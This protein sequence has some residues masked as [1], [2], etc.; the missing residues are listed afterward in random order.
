MATVLVIDDSQS[1]VV[2]F[3]KILQG[4]GFDYMVA[5]DGQSGVAMAKSGQPDLVLMDV[6]MPGLNGFQA[7]RKLS[8]D[9]ATKHI[10]IIMVSTKDQDTDRVWGERQGAKAFLVKPVAEKTL[11]A[12]INRLLA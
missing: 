7:T 10:P 8:Q 5:E 3:S 9:P 11:L 6:V 4:A 2:Q 12:E 1:Q